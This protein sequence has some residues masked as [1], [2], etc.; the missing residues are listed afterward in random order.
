MAC[1]HLNSGDHAMHVSAV[2]EAQIILKWG[3][4]LLYLIVFMFGVVSMFYLYY[5]PTLFYLGAVLGMFYIALI[6]ENYQGKEEE[7]TVEKE[8]E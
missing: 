4:R 8:K 2:L 6:W 3:Y 5:P 7:G 1:Y